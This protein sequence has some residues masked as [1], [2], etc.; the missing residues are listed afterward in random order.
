[1]P[2]LGRIPRS[3]PRPRRRRTCADARRGCRRVWISRRSRGRRRRFPKASR[4][5]RPVPR[6]VRTRVEVL[7]ESRACGSPAEKLPCHSAR[8]REIH[9]EEGADP[10]EVTL[11]VIR[12]DRC[13]GSPKARPIAS[14]MSRVGTPS[15]ATACRWRARRSFRESRSDEA[16][17]IGPVHG[18]PPVGPVSP[19]SP[20]RPFHGPLRRSPRRTRGRRLRGRS[21]QSAGSRCTHRGRGTRARDSHCRRAATPG[22]GTGTHRPP[23]QACPG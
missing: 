9:A 14:A 13:D 11:D 10:P 16:R 12:G 20:R 15:S 6:R 22:H 23:W 17:G 3:L 8:R 4:I 7:N 21:A 19:G 5:H 2:S 1:M 18:G